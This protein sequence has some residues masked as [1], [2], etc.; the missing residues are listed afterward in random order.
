M[1]TFKML[2]VVAAAMLALASCDKTGKDV[3][4]VPVSM[5]NFGFTAELN[6]ILNSDVIVTVGADNGIN[7]LLPFGFP[8]ESLKKLIPTFTFSEGASVTF[9]GT[10]Y[11]VGDAFDFSEPVDIV[12]SLN[13]KSNA[14]YTVTVTVQ[15]APNWMKVAESE[16]EMGCEPYMAI[17]PVNNL[18][19][20]L[21]YRRYLKEGTTT[22]DTDKN[23][24]DL[25]YLEGNVLKSVC[26]IIVEQ[27]ASFFGL[28]FSPEGKAYV[29]LGNYVATDGT[30]KS[31]AQRT[32]VYRVTASG[33]TQ[34]G[35]D[36]VAVGGNTVTSNAV[37]AVSD[38]EIYDIFF[39]NAA[40]TGL[41]LAKRGVDCAKFD[42]SSWTDGGQISDREK[43][44]TT[45]EIITK[46]VAGVPY[47]LILNYSLISVSLYKYENNAWTTVFHDLKPL[48]V[49]GDG[50][51]T[52]GIT[53]ADFQYSSLDFDIASN[54]DVYVFASADFQTAGTKEYGVVR[55][56]R[57]VN[58]GDT[59]EIAAWEQS[60]V[61]GVIKAATHAQARYASF[62]LD[63][64]D[65]PFV[66]WSNAIKD[67][68]IK[69]SVTWIDPETRLWAE[70]VALTDVKT[71][72]AVIRFAEDGTGYIG[73]HDMV[74]NK[75]VLCSNK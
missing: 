31:G 71:E 63:A 12:I 10:P 11:S 1:K 75:Y 7:I 60:L 9:N 50:I 61:G 53:T 68:E 56:R 2:L 42:G 19:Y 64:N 8:K 20:L 49:S 4:P 58:Q 24:P 46:T 29:S 55:A 28:G 32:Q 39:S 41:G 65:N 74:T 51:A 30:I 15:S 6:P 13:E 33:A 27:R 47:V 26:G 45:Y 70:P 62:A 16:I 37:V 54:G 66:V 52:E 34:L 23:F 69:T 40:V 36:L 35:S 43:S 44:I 25:L 22:L 73:Y 14:M 38:S 59:D 21:G 57:V 18:P 17:N 48:Q 67:T 72:G 3:K 5:E